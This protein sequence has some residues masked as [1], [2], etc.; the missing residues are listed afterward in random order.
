MSRPTG[1]AGIVLDK[2]GMRFGGDNPV[3]ALEDI[4]LKIP[5]GEFLAVVGPSG[6][7]K[8]TLLRLVSGL[9]EPTDRFDLGPWQDA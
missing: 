6:C 9:L 3:V 2:V 4:D 1:G 7:G 8:S 5:P